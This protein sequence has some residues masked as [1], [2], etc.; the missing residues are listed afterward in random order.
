MAHL[1][2]QFQRRGF[3]IIELLVVIAIIGV[4]VGMLLPAVQNARESARY[5]QCRNQLKQISLGIHLHES[6]YKKF[7]DGGL[8]WH[9]PRSM[10]NGVPEITPDQNWGWMYQILPFVEQGAIYSEQSDAIVQANT[11]G[12]YFCPS[13]RSEATNFHVGT[14]RALNDYAANG[15][16]RTNPTAHWGD[17][18]TGGFMARRG[19]SS[20]ST[21]ASIIDGLSNTLMVGEKSVNELHYHIATCADNEGW[22]S[23][24]DWDVIRWG[25]ESPEHDGNAEPCQSWFGSAHQG[26]CLFAFGDGS[27][28]TITYSIDQKLFQSLSHREDGEPLAYAP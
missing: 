7:P 1:R 25:N 28:H 10:T 13:R 11:I 5:T 23:G 19:Y 17:G 22:S 8:D 14:T 24:W 3:T 18:L 20:V 12:L 6:Q 4:M 15:G 26:G 2:T 27:V 9:S 21:P 16:I